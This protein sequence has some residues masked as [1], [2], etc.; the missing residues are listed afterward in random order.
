VLKWDLSWGS[1]LKFLQEMARSTGVIPKALLDRPLLRPHL[2]WY[3]N[4]FYEMSAGRDIGEYVP[5]LSSQEMRDYCWMVGLASPA[6]RLRLF[7]VARQLDVAYC[8]AQ[9]EKRL[10]L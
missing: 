7:E 9:N 4:A 5:P 10:Q 3:L 2:A 1:Q 6:R 8:Q